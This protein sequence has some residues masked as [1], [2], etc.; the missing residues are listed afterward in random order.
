[1]G[2]GSKGPWELQTNPGEAVTSLC[3]EKATLLV[4]P[5]AMTT[6]NKREATKNRTGWGL[7]GSRAKITAD[8]LPQLH[9]L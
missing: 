4:C 5:T 3:I 8:Q 9:A 6:R 1:M 7:S 2:V